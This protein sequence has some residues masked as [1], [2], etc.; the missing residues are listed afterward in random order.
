IRNERFVGMRMKHLQGRGAVEEELAGDEKIG[1]SPDI[2]DVAARVELLLARGLFRRHESGRSGEGTLV[3]QLDI[4]VAHADAFHEAEVEQLGHVIYLAALAGKDVAR[5]DIAMDE[6]NTVGLAQS[7]ARL[8][9]EM[10]SPFGR[11]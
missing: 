7:L 2:V 8:P 5:L 11:H 6:A 10:D 4:V 3:R 1:H 9:K